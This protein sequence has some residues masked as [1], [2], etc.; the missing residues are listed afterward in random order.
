MM[1]RCLTAEPEIQLIEHPQHPI[2]PRAMAAE[3]DSEVALAADHGLLP[4]WKRCLLCGTDLELEWPDLSEVNPSDIKNRGRG[5]WRRGAELGCSFCNI[6]ISVFDDAE[7]QHNCQI[8][9]GFLISN[10]DSPQ[11]FYKIEGSQ[12]FLG[13]NGSTGR[14]LLAL[15]FVDMPLL[16][17]PGQQPNYWGIIT[18]YLDGTLPFCLFNHH[19]SPAQSLV[20][21]TWLD[22]VF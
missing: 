7:K 1:S 14:Y 8:P 16:A 12:V 17:E 6:I 10:T 5:E 2:I 21:S 4:F 15:E 9:D 11:C 13:P 19:A 3:H 22:L 20:R 18:I